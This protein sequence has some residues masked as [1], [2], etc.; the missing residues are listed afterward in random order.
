MNSKEVLASDY[1]FT[2]NTLCGD[3]PTTNLI[4]ITVEDLGPPKTPGQI[5]YEAYCNVWRLPPQWSN[6]RKEE[7]EQVAKAVLNA[8]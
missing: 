1:P 8:K 7:W 5:A 3:I 4:R 6:A 2:L